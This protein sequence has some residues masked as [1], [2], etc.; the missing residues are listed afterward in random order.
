[1]T[2][3]LPAVTLLLKDAEARRAEHLSEAQWCALDLMSRLPAGHASEV[4]ER[5]RRAASVQGQRWLDAS[6]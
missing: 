4:E 6:V 2:L 3:E 1:M 5:T